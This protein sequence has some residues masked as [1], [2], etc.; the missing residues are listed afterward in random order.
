M[1]KRVTQAS[2]KAAARKIGFLE[3]ALWAL[4]SLRI[5]ENSRA[6]QIVISARLDVTAIYMTLNPRRPPSMHQ[7]RSI[8]ASNSAS[9]SGRLNRYP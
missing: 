3:V 4:P 9:G 2:R 1:M 8:N 6:K 5:G 7:T